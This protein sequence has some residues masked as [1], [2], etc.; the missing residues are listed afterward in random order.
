MQSSTFL[1]S[2]LLSA[3]LSLVV[4]LSD[5]NAQRRSPL[6]RPPLEVGAPVKIDLVGKPAIAYLKMMGFPVSRGIGETEDGIAVPL[7]AQVVRST[8]KE[9]IAEFYCRFEKQPGQE[10]LLTVSAIVAPIAIRQPL[11]FSTPGNSDDKT[12]SIANNVNSIPFIRAE[13]F[14]TVRFC[15]WIPDESQLSSKR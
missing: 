6:S 7:K 4:V 12:K 15:V 5:A 10:R 14:E 1:R 2:A 13:S 9:V 8:D 11:P 3:F